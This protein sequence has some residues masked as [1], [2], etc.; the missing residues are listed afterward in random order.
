MTYTKFKE[1]WADTDEL[2]GA[3]FNHIE[4][5]WAAAK[6]DIDAHNHDTRY[7]TKTLADTTFFSTS[8]YTGFDADK[9]DGQHLSDLVASI[10]P[11]GAIMIWS[12]EVADLPAEWKKCDGTTYGGVTTPNLQ[13][14]IVIGAGSTY[15]IGATGGAF[16][17][18]I[19]GTITIGGH[20]VIAA[21]MPIHTHSY[22][23][24]SDSAASLYK[25][26]AGS[27]RAGSETY[28]SLNTGYA[29]Y[30]DAATGKHDHP[31]ST[32]TFDPLDCTPPYRALYYIMKVS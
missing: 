2:T 17:T 15:A 32:I 31:G 18:A 19:S 9:V 24:Q 28:Q 27:G 20:A 14:R 6:I 22:T 4:G 29:G 16:S 23:D 13:D 26:Y 7:Y 8:Y 12:R 5:Q 3:A 21:E 10:L 25:Y 30:T 1:A 11:V